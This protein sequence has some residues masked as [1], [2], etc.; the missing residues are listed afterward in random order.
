MA[1]S[2][3]VFARPTSRCAAGKAQD[4]PN[5]RRLGGDVGLAVPREARSQG[6]L[7]VGK[8]TCGLGVGAQVVTKSKVAAPQTPA[9]FHQLHVVG[10]RMHTAQ[11]LSTRHPL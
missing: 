1:E 6:P 11:P 4:L 2:N 3:T 10:P 8:V 7:H 5:G 9:R